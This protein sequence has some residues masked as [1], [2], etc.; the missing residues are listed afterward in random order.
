VDQSPSDKELL[1]R[2]R[3]NGDDVAFAVLVRRYDLHVYRFLVRATRDPEA[4]KD[5]RQ[6]TFI[7]VYRYAATFDDRYAVS[8]WIFRIVVNRLHTWRHTQGRVQAV[9]I[10]IQGAVGTTAPG[11]TP[12]LGLPPS[13]MPRK[14]P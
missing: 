13:P 12:D 4:A 3:R 11:A 1:A 6:E 2:V 9:E 10:P 14:P 8:T 7:R 5:I